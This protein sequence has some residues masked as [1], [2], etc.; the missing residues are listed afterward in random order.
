MDEETSEFFDKV[1]SLLDSISTVVSPSFFFQHLWL[2]LITSPASRVAALNYCGKRLPKVGPE[3]DLTE[4]VGQDVGLM[5]RAFA[6]AVDDGRVLVQRGILDLLLNTIRLDGSGWKHQVRHEDQKLLM[7]SLLG[8]VL[9]RDLSLSRRLHHW[10]LGSTDASGRVDYLQEHGLATVC[11]AL[12]EEMRAGEQRPFRILLA[13]LDKWEIGYPVT[14]ALVLDASRCLKDVMHQEGKEELRM[15]AGVLW[16]GLDP[17]LT[18]K[19]LFGAVKSEMQGESDQ[20][21]VREKFT[22]SA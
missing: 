9:K 18:W 20:T 15:T 7:R 14:E 4:I 12:R 2:I 6:S 10:L 11:E 16:E 22:R 1:S 21:E 17:Y 8:V 19:M 3:D 13:L 5:V